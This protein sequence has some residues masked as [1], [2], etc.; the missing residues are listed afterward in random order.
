M[1]FCSYCNAKVYKTQDDKCSCCENIITRPKKYSHIDRALK[2]GTKQHRHLL[3]NWT[4]FPYGL[5]STYRIEINYRDLVYEIPIKYLALYSEVTDQ[6][7]EEKLKIISKH[8]R[9]KGF[10]IL[11][12]EDE[13]TDMTCTKCHVTRLR[14]N[15]NDVLFCS[16]CDV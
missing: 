10:R 1:E 11:Y 16:K 5:E 8:M 15:K 4:Q 6:K 13:Y 12:P 3:R 14:Y 9:K 2:A 7:E